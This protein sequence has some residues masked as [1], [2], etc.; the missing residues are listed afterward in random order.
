MPI[1]SIV[2]AGYEVVRIMRGPAMLMRGATIMGAPIFL[3]DLIA[4]IIGFL[5]AITG[6]T[7]ITGRP[8][9]VGTASGRFSGRMPS[10]IEKNIRRARRS[11]AAW[12]Y[13]RLYR[14]FDNSQRN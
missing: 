4:A 1:R 7:A 13:L 10:V 6:L 9:R 11:W 12:R 3:I 8:M 14:R 2:G 5:I